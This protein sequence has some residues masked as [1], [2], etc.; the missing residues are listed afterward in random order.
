VGGNPFQNIASCASFQRGQEIPL[1]IRA[2]QHHYFRVWICR[3]HVISAQ[4]TPTRDTDIQQQN[5]SL[6]GMHQVNGFF[7]GCGL[8]YDFD[9][10]FFECSNYTIPKDRVVVDNEDMD[11]ITHTYELTPNI[12]ERGWGNTYFSLTMGSGLY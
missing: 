11:F 1:V 4:N 7:G 3:Q 9:V 6:N 5:I 8:S 12:P 2:G 10:I